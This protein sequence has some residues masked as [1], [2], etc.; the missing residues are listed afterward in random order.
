MRR[1]SQGASGSEGDMKFP[2][3]ASSCHGLEPDMPN[4]SCERHRGDAHANPWR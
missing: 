3:D 1:G 2:E 4:D